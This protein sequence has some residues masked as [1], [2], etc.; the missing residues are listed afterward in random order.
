MTVTG[1]SSGALC[2]FSA[3]VD[4]GHHHESL[5]ARTAHGTDR[6]G[7]RLVARGGSRAEDGSFLLARCRG[8]DTRQRR[9][10]ALVALISRSKKA[11]RRDAWR[12]V[13][14]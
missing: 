6:T 1:L 3:N 9:S 2:L 11:T 13:M 14:P 7:H 5:S 8:H 4:L 10:R 12:G